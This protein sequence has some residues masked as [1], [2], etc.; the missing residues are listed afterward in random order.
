MH[1]CEGWGKEG[2]KFGA[3]VYLRDVLDKLATAED[4]LEALLPD[5]WKAAHP[6]HVREFRVV[7]RQQQA[8]KRRYR[9]ATKRI[10]AN[11]NA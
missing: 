3:G 8:D 10:A 6:E 4:E 11:A 1:I 9:W 5:V 2:K 7:E